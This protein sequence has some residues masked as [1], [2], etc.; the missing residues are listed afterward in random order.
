MLFFATSCNKSGGLAQGNGKVLT[1]T[2]LLPNSPQLVETILGNLLAHP[3]LVLRRPL[4]H[5]KRHRCPLGRRRNRL[6]LGFLPFGRNRLFGLRTFG[7]LALALFAILL[8]L[9]GLTLDLG[10]I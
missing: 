5:L 4:H 10:S 9:G 1:I 7:S 3:N 6:D 2:H 8:I